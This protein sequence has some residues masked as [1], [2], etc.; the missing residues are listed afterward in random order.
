MCIVVCGYVQ[1]D[2]DKGYIEKIMKF[3]T[4]GKGYKSVNLISENPIFLY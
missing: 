3:G 2:R 1:V 4:L